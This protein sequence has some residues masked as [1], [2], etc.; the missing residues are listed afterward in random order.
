MLVQPVPKGAVHG[1][2]G[3]RT[4]F[5]VAAVVVAVV[6]GRRI[7]P[8]NRRAMTRMSRMM[9]VRVRRRRRRLLVLRL[10]MVIVKLLRLV[11][12]M[13][14]SMDWRPVSAALHRG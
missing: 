13:L 4:E 2:A 5:K 9:I 12:Q 14:V 6:I 7:G 8:M 3:V 10:M 1:A 11:M